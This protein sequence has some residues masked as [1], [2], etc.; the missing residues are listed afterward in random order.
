[1]SAKSR[2]D[3]VETELFVRVWGVKGLDSKYAG[4]AVFAKLSLNSVMHKTTV[5]HPVLND[6]G[7]GADIA[8]FQKCV[9]S[10]WGIKKISNLSYE[11]LLIVRVKYLGKLGRVK[12]LGVVSLAVRELSQLGK[13]DSKA[14]FPLVAYKGAESA[15]GKICIGIYWGTEG[16]ACGLLGSPSGKGKSMLMSRPRLMSDESLSTI[17]GMGVT[18]SRSVSSSLS[19]PF[20]TV[21]RLKTVFRKRHHKTQE[22]LVRSG[23]KQQGM[24]LS[25]TSVEK[26]PDT[27][28]DAPIMNEDEETD[29]DDTEEEEED[30]DQLKQ[31]ESKQDEKASKKETHSRPFGLFTMSPRRRQ[32]VD[33]RL[34]I[35]ELKQQKRAVLQVE[36]IEARGLLA[37]DSNGLSDPY[38]ILKVRQAKRKTQVIQKTLTPV[39]NQPFVFGGDNNSQEIISLDDI[40]TIIVK[41][42]DNVG[43]DDDLGLIEIP[44]WGIAAK[45]EEVFRSKS[46]SGSTKLKDIAEDQFTEQPQTRTPSFRAGSLAEVDCVVT[47]PKWY[48]LHALPGMSTVR[49]EIKLGLA[50]F[51]GLQAN[52]NEDKPSEERE[53]K[54]SR[55]FSA[56]MESITTMVQ[57]SISPRHSS[58]E[59]KEELQEGDLF[60]EELSLFC[61]RRSKPWNRK[62]TLL[63]VHVLRGKN[64]KVADANGKS[65]PYCVVKVRHT[66]RQTEI[67]RKTLDPVWNE[68]L[69]FGQYF[70]TENDV[71]DI[72]VR[73]YDRLVKDDDLGWLSIPIWSIL[74]QNEGEPKWF[75]VKPVVQKTKASGS[76]STSPVHAAGST[77]T[78]TVLTPTVATSEGKELLGEIQ[79]AF[80]FQ[81]GDTTA[82]LSP[83]TPKLDDIV[84]AKMN[85]YSNYKGKVWFYK[86]KINVISARDLPSNLDTG[87]LTSFVTVTCGDKTERTKIVKGS[88]NPLYKQRFTFEGSS[89]P[90]QRGLG[91][92]DS[93]RISVRTPKIDKGDY[94]LDVV[95]SDA[96]GGQVIASTSINLG[97]V[98]DKMGYIDNDG[99]QLQASFELDVQRQNEE[100][101]AVS[102]LDAATDA[103]NGI[104]VAK[105]RIKLSIKLF[106]VAQTR[107]MR[108][109]KLVV[110]INR[111]KGLDEP[112][113]NDL[114][115][116]VF[117]ETHL[118]CFRDQSALFKMTHGY[119]VCHHVC[120]IDNLD[121]LENKNGDT[122]LK[123]NVCLEGTG[124]PIAKIAVPIHEIEAAPEKLLENW[125][126]LTWNPVQELS[127]SGD[128]PRK[129]N[130]AK[131][132][133]D[134]AAIHAS[135]KMCEV[136][137]YLEPVL[138]NVDITLRSCE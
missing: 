104:Q 121:A 24:T 9:F 27:W 76:P 72:K 38:C 32:V 109:K 124:R 17:G 6:S 50:Y 131:I 103:V 62:H 12:S 129:S 116:N 46:L 135:I 87:S 14:W 16:D 21:S 127:E 108:R 101:E 43:F 10:G 35:Q 15:D 79:L 86:M 119:I 91:R 1:M 97:Y 28:H 58:V 96:A 71:I 75:A 48:S 55:P 42:K 66:K 133:V 98:I 37:A 61:S 117:L 126:P 125:L 23:A 3:D 123:I 137:E 68:T 111:A 122:S 115:R 73:D 44:L 5:S 25:S 63:K 45:S 90:S 113:K 30:D 95:P 138:G 102:F 22:M 33:K 84:T 67:K 82:S 51:P 59:Q 107:L 88:V 31:V 93:I 112:G 7:Q 105:P 132:T 40:V 130:F 94:L 56:P 13:P 134:D 70:L 49:G 34:S 54:K 65:D 8:D 85:Q 47:K 128:S 39:W 69:E 118:G 20:K 53:K 110:R 100:E 19:S 77:E 106:P 26:E 41:D 80:S 136:A 36:I 4:K 92:Q 74:E 81:V 29:V 18:S 64:L 99:M 2:D 78:A 89:A 60:D 120:Y 83:V 57:H 52:T 11:D 114:L